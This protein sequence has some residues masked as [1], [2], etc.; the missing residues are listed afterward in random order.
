MTGFLDSRPKINWVQTGPYSPRLTRHQR[1]IA[2]ASALASVR[3]EGLDPSGI[4]GALYGW[5]SG[6]TTITEV[7][8]RELHDLARVYGPPT[9]KMATTRK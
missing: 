1:A 3:A 5:V 9:A 8:T 6:E 2:A 7:I 4:A